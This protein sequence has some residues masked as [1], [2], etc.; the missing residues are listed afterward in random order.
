MSNTNLWSASCRRD[1]IT[2]GQD[3]HSSL[4]P[5]S[6]NC[7]KHPWGKWSAQDK[8]TKGSGWTEIGSGRGQHP[9]RS[10]RW[11][12]EVLPW[13]EDQGNSFLLNTH[14]CISFLLCSLLAISS[15]LGPTSQ[16]QFLHHFTTSSEWGE[17]MTMEIK[18]ERREEKSVSHL[19][20]SSCLSFGASL[21]FTI[22]T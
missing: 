21:S 4:E 15:S 12:Q 3:S 10:A 2:T 9:S 22:K 18:K 1:P 19:L 5:S 17:Q 8:V 20:D 7:E 11:A 14:L 6:D 16:L 13:L